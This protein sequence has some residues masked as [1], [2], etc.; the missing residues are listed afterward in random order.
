MGDLVGAVRV[1][2]DPGINDG[3]EGDADVERTRRSKTRRAWSS[4]PTTGARIFSRRDG[5]DDA[6]MTDLPVE[7]D[8]VSTADDAPVEDAS[9]E[10]DAA[11][12]ASAEDSACVPGVWMCLGAC[13]GGWFELTRGCGTGCGAC[14]GETPTGQ[15]GLLHERRGIRVPCRPPP[16]A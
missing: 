1:R 3:D 11:E 4:T 14:D 10:D 8:D 16:W 13:P 7:L 5:G 12:D 2:C 6:A 15:R 9:V